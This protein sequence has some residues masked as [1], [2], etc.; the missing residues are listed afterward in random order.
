MKTLLTVSIMLLV[1]STAAVSQSPDW[2]R[3]APEG[4]GFSILLPQT[5]KLEDSL[6]PSGRAIHRSISSDG[7]IKGSAFLATYWDFASNTVFS[8]D[9]LRDSVAPDDPRQIISESNISIDGHA[10]REIQKWSTVGGRD[11][12]WQ[13][14]VYI[15]G[16]RVYMLQFVVPKETDDSLIESKAAKFFDSFSIRSGN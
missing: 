6:Q 9:K 10:G 16:Q 2:V 12:R 11:Y 14:R 4:K 15:I 7:E 3:Y 13:V 8:L 1:F 5:P